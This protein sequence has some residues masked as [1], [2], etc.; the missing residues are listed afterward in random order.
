MLD[1][2]HHKIHDDGWQ[3]PKNPNTGKYQL[4]PPTHPP[5]KPPNVSP[6]KPARN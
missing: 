3:V 1:D 5:D 2:G 4:K 6:D